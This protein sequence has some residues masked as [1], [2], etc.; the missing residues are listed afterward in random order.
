MIPMGMRLPRAL[1]SFM[2]TPPSFMGTPPSFMG[3]PPS[4]MAVAL[5]LVDRGIR[6]DPA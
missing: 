6:T 2:G 3:T 4:F 5:S 1:L